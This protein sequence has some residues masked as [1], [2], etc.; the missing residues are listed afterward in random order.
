MHVGLE[1]SC[2]MNK[3]DNINSAAVVLSCVASNDA[4]L[5]DP[6]CRFDAAIQPMVMVLQVVAGH[7]VACFPTHRAAV[8]PSHLVHDLVLT[9][10]GT[11]YN[12]VASSSTA[13]QKFAATF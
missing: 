3:Q 1:C 4:I 8:P 6:N 5:S 7:D 10:A 11:T 13:G 12:V 9:C 2:S